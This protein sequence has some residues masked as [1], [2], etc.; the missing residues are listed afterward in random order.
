MPRYRSPLTE[1][2][3]GRLAGTSAPASS[4]ATTASWIARARLALTESPPGTSASFARRDDQLT[5][6]GGMSA[7]VCRACGYAELYVTDPA[8]LVVD[9]KHVREM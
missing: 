2:P 4:V 7:T 9:G 6:A 1:K 8:S 3:T 5:V